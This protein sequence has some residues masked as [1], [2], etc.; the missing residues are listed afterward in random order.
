MGEAVV[1]CGDPAEVLEASEHAFDG[2]AM[3]IEIGREA[4]LPAPVGLGRDVGGSALC[5]DLSAHGVAVVALVAVQDLS[6]SEVVEQGVGGDAIGHLAAGQ[7]ERDRAA[8]AVGQRM[9]F[10]GP[11]AARAPD[12]LALLPP[13]PPEAQR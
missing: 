2:V 13:F 7:E 5:L 10:C 4:A 3:A 1:A 12:R 11:S 6:G 9:D 8:E